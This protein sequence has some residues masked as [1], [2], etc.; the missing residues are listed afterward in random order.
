MMTDETYQKIEKELGLKFMEEMK[1]LS[2]VDLH[3]RIVQA[4]NAVKKADEEL[5]ANPTYQELKAAMKDVKAARNALKKRQNAITK[6]S[7]ELLEENGE[8]L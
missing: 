2:R 5:E 6:Y 1:A 4:E 8:V 3:R 7:L